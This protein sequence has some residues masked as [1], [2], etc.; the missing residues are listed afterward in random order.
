MLD[1]DETLAPETHGARNVIQFHAAPTTMNEDRRKS[2]GDFRGSVRFALLKLQMGG[3]Q[4]MQK[5]SPLR[6][7]FN[8]STKK[9]CKVIRRP[10]N[11]FRLFDK[12]IGP[13]NFHGNSAAAQHTSPLARHREF[14][15]HPGYAQVSGTRYVTDEH[16]SASETSFQSQ[17]V[18]ER[19]N[20]RR[21]ETVEST[22]VGSPRSSAGS[23]VSTK[24]GGSQKS[25]GR[26][27]AQKKK[28]VGDQASL[29]C[30][31]CT[32]SY[33]TLSALSLHLRLKH[34]ELVRIMVDVSPSQQ[35]QAIHGRSVAAYVNHCMK[36]GYY[37]PKYSPEEARRKL[38]AA[39]L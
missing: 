33:D 13:S 21:R 27:K 4:P 9:I 16:R 8:S 2:T 24:A 7:E 37:Y 22:D 18:Y 15:A 25:S 29:H 20:K 10:V 36:P 17:I 5:L 14:V 38:Q 19:P 23:K 12:K 34:H 39:S 31:F 32:K 11:D 26:R 6:G 35:L 1:G 28:P 3:K 30:S